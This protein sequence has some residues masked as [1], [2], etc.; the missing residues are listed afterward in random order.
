[1]HEK[2]ACLMLVLALAFVQSAHAKDGY[3]DNTGRADAWQG[4]VRMIPITTPKGSFR[5]WTPE[6]VMRSIAHMNRAINVPTQGPSEMSASGRLV[7]WDRSQ[8]LG[9]IKVP[10]LVIVGGHDTMDPKHMEWMA[11]QFPRG[12]FLLC[13][14]GG[15]MAFYD[16]PEPYFKGLPAFLKDVEGMP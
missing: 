11:K 6:P 3:F 14:E 4:G 12:R 13:P 7:N 5:V 1:M 10:T 9:R 8:D 16:D 2:I 15:H